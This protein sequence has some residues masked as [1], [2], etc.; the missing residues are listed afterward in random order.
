MIL[1]GNIAKM[2]TELNGTE[3]KYWLK[4]GEQEIEISS[5]LGKNFTFEYT[6]EINCVKCGRKTNK[7]FS[8]GFCYP[9]FTTAPETEECVLRPELCKAHEGQARDMEYAEQHC[10]KDQYVYLA[11]A[12]SIKVGVTR[13]TQIPTRWIDQG[14]SYALPI[15]KAPNRHTAGLIEV[16]LKPVFGDKTNWRKMLANDINTAI[17]LYVERQKAFDT[18]GSTFHEFLLKDEEIRE[19]TYPNIHFPEKVLLQ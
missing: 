7:S 17:D 12:S 10:L 3:A 18:L 11:V 9:C 1:S 16:A 6:G 8:Q 5:L 14:A 13:H 4:A 15:A 2:R 19:I